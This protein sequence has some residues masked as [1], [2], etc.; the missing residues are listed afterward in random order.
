MKMG[1]QTEKGREIKIANDAMPNMA[2]EDRDIYLARRDTWARSVSVVKQIVERLMA[3]NRTYSPVTNLNLGYEA[4]S[5]FP[6]YGN[7]MFVT[8][9]LTA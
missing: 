3:D 5:A 6:A 2:L 7:R 8:R 1:D 4:Q 9:L